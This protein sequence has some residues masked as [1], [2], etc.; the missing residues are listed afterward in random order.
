MQR[1][2]LAVLLSLVT[3]PA[4]AGGVLP[5]PAPPPVVVQSPQNDWTG[6]YGGAQI[7]LIVDGLLS[8]GGAPL[9]DVEGTLFGGFI[10]YRHDFG[11][12]VLGAELDA[13]FGNSTAAGV[14]GNLPIADPDIGTTLLRAGVEVGVDLGPVLAY[15]TAGAAWIDWE[16]NGG[17]DG[18]GYFAG[19]GADMRLS[20][21]TTLGIEVLHHRFEDF[22]GTGEL[23]FTTVGLNVAFRF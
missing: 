17:S 16:S 15:G 21:N 1:V 12:L 18:D 7:D 23:E 3:A 6:A 2:S 19:L 9:A 13:M 5:Q 10:G 22:G 11:T 8:D 4:L 14:G 20:E